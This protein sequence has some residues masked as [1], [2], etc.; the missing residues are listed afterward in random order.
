MKLKIVTYLTSS[1][2]AF[3]KRL[4]RRATAAFTL[5]EVLMAVMIAAIMFTGVFAAL[6]SGTVIIQSTRENLR[7]TQVMES[8]MEGLRLIAWGYSTNQ[9]FDTNCVPST[10]TESFYPLGVSGN[11]G[12]Q[13]VV[14]YGSMI[15]QTNPILIPSSSYRTQMCLV[16]VTLNWT[17]SH[18][19]IQN[20]H[21][22]KMKTYVAQYGLQNYIWAT[23]N[24]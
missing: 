7:A 20:A 22:R 13:G 24:N 4:K 2:G 6:S 17:N 18:Y 9:L 8:R 11:S 16:T 10:F 21:S 12:S 23:T 14:Y 3:I 15:I 5:L 1:D 19:G